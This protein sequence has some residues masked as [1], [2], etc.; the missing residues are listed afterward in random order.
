MQVSNVR[1]GFATNSSSSHSIVILP[2]GDR[3]PR[4]DCDSS[5]GGYGWEN[6]VLTSEEEKMRYFAAQL[7]ETLEYAVGSEITQA[8]L[9]DFLGVR[10]NDDWYVDHASHL[11]FPIDSKTGHL[12]WSFIKDLQM[13]LK[14]EDVVV[15]GGNDND[16]VEH[17]YSD[18]LYDLREVAGTLYAAKTGKW[19]TLFNTRNGAK[20]RLSF[21]DDGV[22][23]RRSL[24]PEL[25]DMHIT[26]YCPF[27]CK[28][29]YQDSTVKGGIA[30]YEDVT[31]YL[32]QLQGTFEVAFGGGEPTFHPDFVRI[33][34]YAKS[35]G[36]IPN[37]TTKVMPISWSQEL[38]ETTQ[39]ICGGFAVSLQHSYDVAK[40]KLQCVKLGLEEQVHVHY[41]VGVES[42][43]YLEAMIK[44]CHEENIPLT[45][46]GFKTTGRGETFKP[47][48]E[49][50]R[51]ES[52]DKAWNVSV[53]TAF[54]ELYPDILAN[55][56]DRL[57][58]SGE[59]RFSMYVDAVNKQ[60]GISSYHRDTFISIGKNLQDTWHALGDFVD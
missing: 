40:L 42:Y 36:I 45:L 35:V 27:N 17:H 18:H 59:G 47:A 15:F 19:W 22:E 5:D 49:P 6:F 26:D 13:F 24:R 54:V 3:A 33:L 9:H 7:G 58:T 23:L 1:L 43:H 14:R 48:K 38:V 10:W 56:S 60:A 32:Y 25:V 37:F 11:T 34:R 50:I 51:K 8:V 16:G 52:L 30:S 55:I 53:D 57:I 2:K 21:F 4:E 44:A 12:N 31:D 46:L 28:F 29:C 20:I 41:V 39:E